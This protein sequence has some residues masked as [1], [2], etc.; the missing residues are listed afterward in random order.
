[1]VRDLSLP[2]E[3][4]GCR[5]VRA[6]DGLALSSRNVRLSPEQR[7]AALALS[8]ALRTAAGLIAEGERR[9][10]T[11]EAA[12][13]EVVSGEPLVALDYAA[14]VYA[15]DLEPARSCSGDRPLR[16]LI[17]AIVGPVRLIDNLDPTG[18]PVPPPVPAL[19]SDGPI[20]A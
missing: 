5:T 16:V 11:V 4:V 12:M 9:T 13:V 1:M 17:A 14:V 2:T 20:R 19:A 10:D 7:R 15:D 6:D 18:P 8:R 3:V